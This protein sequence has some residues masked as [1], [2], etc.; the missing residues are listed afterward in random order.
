MLGNFLKK[1]PSSDSFQNSLRNNFS[2][3]S[4]LVQHQALLSALVWVQTVRKG[5][6]QTTQACNEIMSLMLKPLLHNMAFEISCI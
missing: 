6:Q 3:S 2:V 5:Y 4:S 1:L